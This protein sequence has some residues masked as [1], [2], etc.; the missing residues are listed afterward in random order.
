MKR[1]V[2]KYFEEHLQSTAPVKQKQKYFSNKC[3]IM[4]QLCID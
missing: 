3:K 4:P 1:P 2:I